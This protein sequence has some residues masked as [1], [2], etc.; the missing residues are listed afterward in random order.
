MR[1]ANWRHDASPM[2][3]WRLVIYFW[4]HKHASLKSFRGLSTDDFRRN[5][6]AVSHPSTVVEQRPKV[7]EET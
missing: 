5:D 1:L 4:P 6:E 2:G 3:G 7:G